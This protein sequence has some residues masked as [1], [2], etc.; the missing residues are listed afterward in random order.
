MSVTINNSDH[1]NWDQ[2][3][4]WLNSLI[5]QYESN[6]GRPRPGADPMQSSIIEE[7]AIFTKH[8]GISKAVDDITDQAEDTVSFF[9]RNRDRA[10]RIPNDVNTALSDTATSVRTDINSAVADPVG[11]L[12]RNVGTDI[13]GFISRNIMDPYRGGQFGLNNPWV[14]REIVRSDLV[15]WFKDCYSCNVRINLDLD[16][17]LPEFAFIEMDLMGRLG[18]LLDL[19]ISDLDQGPFYASLCSMISLGKWCIP[20]I[21][22]LRAVLDL[23]LFKYFQID[24]NLDFDWMGIVLAIV[25]P[26]LKTIN[27]TISASVNMALSPFQ[28]L[29]QMLNDLKTLWESLEN[30]DV[31]ANLDNGQ[32]SASISN[33]TLSS[34][35]KKGFGVGDTMLSFSD[36]LDGIPIV[37]KF[38]LALEDGSG[39]MQE[40]SNFIN[41][42]LQALSAKGVDS[43][44][45]SVK[46]INVISNIQRMFRFVDFIASLVSAGVEICHEEITPVGTRTFVPNIPIP[47]LF[48]SYNIAPP[49]VY[50]VPGGQ[51]TNTDQPASVGIDSST[52]VTGYTTSN[53]NE[54]GS[55]GRGDSFTI[56]DRGLQTKTVLLS[57]NKIVEKQDADQVAKWIQELNEF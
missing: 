28:C 14:E 23:L 19:V 43:M 18:D 2:Y 24:I 20:D 50:L 33:S 8:Y 55:S 46:I 13:G 38:I 25:L 9:E 21:L 32:L 35:G 5:K 26:V 39:W 56:I 6:V 17:Q 51:D 15:E 11:T 37:D 22:A 10:R 40:L 29:E 34:I 16:L 45:G 1:S 4:N 53:T 41:R 47:D 57:C 42:K 3:E 44:F 7:A 30:F 48:T 54:P 36:K 52:T 31:D 49:W 12:D 27:R